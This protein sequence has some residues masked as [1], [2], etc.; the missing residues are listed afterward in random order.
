MYY[1][2]ADKSLKIN[3]STIKDHFV[4]HLDINYNIYNVRGISANP[5]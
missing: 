3:E 4:L 2:C 1:F 5:P